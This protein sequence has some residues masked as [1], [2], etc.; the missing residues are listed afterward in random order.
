MFATRLARFAQIQEH[1]RR[2]VYA[3]AGIERRADQLQQS[4]IVSRS[5][6]LRL[7]QPGVVAARRDLEYSAHKPDVE[8]VAVEPHEL[9]NLPCSSRTEFRDHRRSPAP[10]LAQELRVH[11][12]GKSNQ[13]PW[14]AV[15]SP[16]LLTST[17]TT[18]QV[19]PR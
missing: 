1:S 3:V 18:A 16:S 5:L 10:L 13:R 6:T 15:S 2:A 12:I 14:I 11:E 19:Q 7:L 17:S 9:I 4:R 8:S